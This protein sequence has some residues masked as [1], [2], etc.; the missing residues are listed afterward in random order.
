MGLFH[1]K[2]E[3]D[4]ELRDFYRI[5]AQQPM[6]SNLSYAEKNPVVASCISKISTTCASIPFHV[7]VHT[8]NGVVEAWD[9]WLTHVIRNPNP[10]ETTTVFFSTVVRQ[11][12]AYG[13][14][15]IKLIRGSNDVIVA[16]KIVDAASVRVDRN[17][18][19]EKLFYINGG[20]VLTDHDILHIINP[21]AGYNGTIG[22]PATKTFKD[23]IVMNN[24]IRAFINV[25]FEGGCADKI[26]VTLDKDK[27]D[28][29]QE[30]Q[31]E[32][33]YAKFIEMFKT[34]VT[35]KTGPNANNPLVTPPGTTFSTLTMPKNA[36]LQAREMLMD[37]NK[38]IYNLFH[39]PGELMTDDVKGVYNT[40]N[41]RMTDFVNACIRP[42]CNLI[43]EAFA[44]LLGAGSPY[45]VECDYKILTETNQQEKVTNIVTL[46]NNGLISIN[47]ARKE[48][49]MDAIEG[50]DRFIL[51]LNKG[52]VGNPSEAVSN[53]VVNNVSAEE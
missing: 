15:Y 38:E 46:L 19:G 22:L 33:M 13:N 21:D 34:F 17:G 3:K 11:L 5:I 49:H 35:G 40:L 42:I 44:Q 14:C 16:M 4:L 32:K 12:L 25:A 48:L 23:L 28:P 45:F 53:N 2:K 29:M 10:E 47:E 24:V 20:E 39:I 50:G 41:S 36:E 26:V 37:S 30:K 1:T 7:H 31:F 43:I 18:L 27:F 51:P 6:A 9:H 52:T 8:K